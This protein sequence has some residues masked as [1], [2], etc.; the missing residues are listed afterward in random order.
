MTGA[1]DPSRKRARSPTLD[2]MLASTMPGKQP[3]LDA[4][5]QSLQGM[6]P[7]GSSGPGSLQDA[8]AQTLAQTAQLS[9]FQGSGGGGGEGGMPPLGL[10]NMNMMGLGLRS[11]MNQMNQMGQ[12]NQLNQLGQLGHFAGGGVA[13]AVP[14][15]L[16][17][18]VASSSSSS[19]RRG[20]HPRSS[21]PFRE[22]S[23]FAND[24]DA[25]EPNPLLPPSTD[26]LANDMLPPL[27]GAPDSS[28]SSSLDSF[29]QPPFS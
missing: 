11:P 2:L 26:P 21:S 18:D 27:L 16:R 13:S 25:R 4:G 29:L 20:S 3:R 23:P 15:R 17:S 8:L 7:L 14:A 19:S 28:N 5:P 6:P 12:L 1:D 9:Q 10:N 22:S 24:L